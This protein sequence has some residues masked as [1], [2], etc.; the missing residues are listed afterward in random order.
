MA[1]NS[2]TD[3]ERRIKHMVHAESVKKKAEIRGVHFEL[4]RGRHRYDSSYPCEP[5]SKRALTLISIATYLDFFSQDHC[6]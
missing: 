1:E 4:L 5:E 6:T 3:V 2:L